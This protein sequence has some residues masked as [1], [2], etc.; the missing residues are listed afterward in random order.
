MIVHMLISSSQP[1]PSRCSGLGGVLG[2]GADVARAADG[3]D[4]PR[5][6]EDGERRLDGARHSDGL[7]GGRG[8]GRHGDGDVDGRG[9]ALQ[10]LLRGPWRG[11]GDRLRV[12]DGA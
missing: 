8:R 10:H 9:L 4:G 11:E 6:A 12:R 5:S 3:P 7:T 1:A 2:D